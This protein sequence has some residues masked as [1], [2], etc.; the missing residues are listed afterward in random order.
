M[1]E[2]TPPVA[3]TQMLI[4]RPASAVYAAFIDPAITSRFWFSRGSA[5]LTPGAHVTWY[6]D[7]YGAAAQVDVV[8]LEEH[9]RIAVRWPTPVEWVFEPRGEGATLV[10]ITASGFT[11]SPDEQVS[12]A[13]DSMGGFSFVLAGCKAWLEHAVELNLV[14]DHNPDHHAAGQA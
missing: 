2:I 8:A 14:L 9:R 1:P 7:M 12:R 13:I 5:V 6:W 11:G 10:T 3:R 4:R